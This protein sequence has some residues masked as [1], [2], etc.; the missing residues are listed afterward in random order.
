MTAVRPESREAQQEPEETPAPGG[1]RVDATMRL[2]AVSASPGASQDGPG[3]RPEDTMQLRTVSIPETGPGAKPAAGPSAG[4]DDTVQLRTVSI[5]SAGP[6]A[7][8]G[9]PLSAGPGSPPPA[10]PEDTMQLRTVSIPETKPASGPAPGRAPETG[11]EDDGQAEAG[12]ED[13]MQLRLPVMPPAVPAE[14][15]LGGRAERRR[16]DREQARG[17]GRRGAAAEQPA[18]AARHG[19]RAAPGRARGREPVSVKIVRAAGELCVTLGV[20]LLLFV[21]YQLWWTNVRA[22]AAASGTA[23]RLEQQWDKG[24]SGGSRDPDDPRD[25]GAFAP[26]QGFAIIWI[27]KLDVKAP[28]AEGTDKHSVLDKGMVGHYSG[29]LETAM[30]WDKTGNFALAAHRNTH[31]E[32]FR[33]INKLAVGDKVVVETAK[34]YYTYAITSALPQTPP[35]N[36]SVIQPVPVGSGF[37][38]PGRYITLTTCTPEFTS[39]Y[40]LILWGKMVEER[41]RSKGKPDALL[42]S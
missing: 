15:P 26:G 40:R 36:V 9:S 27:P 5:P 30:P 3:A 14:V 1:P 28:I 32:P 4:P 31:G 22:H 25:P 23:N 8:P 41:P 24:N 39:T 33:Y 20:L 35:S 13:T 42:G 2:R 21:S 38:R 7:G 11:T 16:A 37:T 34:A 17:R 10:G 19:R 29:A 6:G 18:G 12:S